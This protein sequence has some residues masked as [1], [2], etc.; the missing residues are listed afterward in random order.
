MNGTCKTCRWWTGCRRWTNETGECARLSSTV[1][2]LGVPRALPHGAWLRTPETFGC[3]L[4]EMEE[5]R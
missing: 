4:H 1:D 3:T 5:K 2:V